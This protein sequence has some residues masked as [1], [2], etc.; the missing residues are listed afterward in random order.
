MHKHGYSSLARILPVRLPLRHPPV[1]INA[2]ESDAT[3]NMRRRRRRFNAA[4]VLWAGRGA[5]LIDVS[6]VTASSGYEKSARAGRAGDA[7]ATSAGSL[8]DAVNDEHDDPLGYYPGPVLLTKRCS[9]ST[10]SVFEW[11]LHLTNYP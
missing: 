1:R 11:M 8:M 2:R 4:G 7:R 10:H 3:F 9:S 5:A 6:C